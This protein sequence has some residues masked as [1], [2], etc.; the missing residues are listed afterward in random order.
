[1]FYSQQL[2]KQSI[3]NMCARCE[4]KFAR[5][6]EYHAHV[7]L[8]VCRRQ[9]KPFNISG[10]SKAQIVADWESKHQGAIL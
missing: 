8:N 6:S 10:K 2:I 1:M 4:T 5:W 7:T 9:I 3:D